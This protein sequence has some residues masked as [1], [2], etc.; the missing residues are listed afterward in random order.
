MRQPQIIAP[1]LRFTT[2]RTLRRFHQH[3]THEGIPLLA[4]VS[5]PLPAA[6][7]DLDALV[8][9]GRE[10]FNRSYY[11]G[12][13]IYQLFE[14]EAGKIS[15]GWVWG[16]RMTATQ[17]VMQDG[18][19]RASGGEGTILDAVREAQSATMPD[20]VALGLATSEHST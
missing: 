19:A 9:V 5:E 16:P 6:A 11:S 15:D 2:H 7:G 13:D 20:L 3:P 12:Q 17:H 8:A 4:D 18:F 10:A 1:H 14:T